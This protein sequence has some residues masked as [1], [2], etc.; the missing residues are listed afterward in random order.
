MH[1]LHCETC[2]KTMEINPMDG[3]DDGD[4]RFSILPL[5]FPLQ[6]LLAY[7]NQNKVLVSSE[8]YHMVVTTNITKD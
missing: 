5:L 2:I 6:A 3:V 1:N 4:W 8:V 7:I